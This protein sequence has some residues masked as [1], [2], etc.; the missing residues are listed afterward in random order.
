MLYIH[1]IIV[2]NNTFV[3]IY[4]FQ[5]AARIYNIFNFD[6][7]KLIKI[8]NLMMIPMNAR[9]F[10]SNSD[11]LD[12]NWIPHNYFEIIQ[13]RIVTN[14]IYKIIPFCNCTVGI[15]KS[16][17]F[18]SNKNSYNILS[19]VAYRNLSDASLNSGFLSRVDGQ[20]KG[21]LEGRKEGR[22]FQRTGLVKATQHY[23]ASCLSLMLTGTRLLIGVLYRV[24]VT[25]WR[26]PLECR[27]SS[28]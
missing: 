22:T 6:F 17:W 14:I 25:I 1:I 26:T 27:S 11:Y 23:N 3:F 12:I 21:F 20:Q 15:S 18:F 2:I 4:R 28:I 7:F 24:F 10:L 16:D 13:A 8:R 19:G 9:Y 5:T